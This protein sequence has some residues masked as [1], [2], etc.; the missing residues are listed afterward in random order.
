[1]AN[2]E[3]RQFGDP[4]LR[5]KCKAVPRV[6]NSIRKTLDDM[7][8]TMRA[9][10]GAGLAAP[11][12]GISK[13]M[14]VVDIGEGPY[15][16]VNPEVVSASEETQTGIEG[17]LSWP[18]YVGE[19]E[20]P[21]RVT[22]KALDRDDHDVWIEGEGYLARALLHEIDHL[23][24][25]L[26]VDRATTI[27]EV[28][29]EPEEQT[30][31]ESG[32]EAL[33][34]SPLKAVFMGSP[35]F[36]VPSLDE[37]VNA[38][39]KVELVVTQPDRPFGRKREL[40]ATPVK[41]RAIELDLPVLTCEDVGDPGVVA[42]IREIA[43]DFVVVAAFG[44]K[45]PTAVLDAPALAC[46]N[47]HP[48]LLP[49]YRGGNPIQRA[50]MNGDKATGVTIIHLSEK[51]DA[52]D[53]VL[54]KTVEI[55]P[56]ETFGTLLKRL[57]SLGAH[58]LIQACCL[59]AA[60]SDRRTP[61]DEALATTARHLR[62]GEEIID[63][64]KSRESVHNLVRALSPRPGA[65]TFVDKERIKIWETRIPPVSTAHSARYGSIIGIEGDH[66]LVQ[67]GDGPL[68]V[69]LVQP[70]GRKPMSAKAF[71]I[72]RSSVSSFSNGGE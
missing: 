25:V 52:G 51:M 38:G 63:W 32:A 36:A 42:K 39:V 27:S 33:S 47:V 9:A 20:R 66:A 48:S 62:R 58:A 60:G 67:C 8:E 1:L 7:L 44:Q 35:E 30:D 19:V 18:G 31:G 6:N 65:V 37:L 41:E 13:R 40:R 11:Q 50:I 54:Q 68:A 69:L 29:K 28:K 16:L 64:S 49:K 45:L 34:P 26:Y 4:V 59:V 56:N 21:L 12:V 70:E 3:I 43:P 57:A 46:L 10:S 5:K 72:G 71:L 23:D 61:Q 55:G 15:F 2:L 22:V 17:C 53:I 24:G 14:V